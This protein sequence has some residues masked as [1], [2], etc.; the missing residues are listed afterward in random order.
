MGLNQ[1]VL[2]P[3]NRG[4]YVENTT[5]DFIKIAGPMFGY[6][7]GDP[8]KLK[9]PNGRPRSVTGER[10]MGAIEKFKGGASIAMLM[11]STGCCRDSLREIL[12]ILMH[13]GQIKKVMKTRATYNRKHGGDKESAHYLL[14]NGGY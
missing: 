7:G 12:R 1:T 8:I 4:F 11:E 5:A 9:K 10:I 13:N 2:I 6:R 3:G 14:I